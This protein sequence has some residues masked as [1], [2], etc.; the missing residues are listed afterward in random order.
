MGYDLLSTLQQQA[1]DL[2]YYKSEPPMACPNDG[3]PLLSG[4]TRSS[5]ELY[6]PNGDF[7][8]PRDWDPDLHS[9]L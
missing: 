1:A 6:C 2:E 9:G 4:S 8:Y 3:T 7:H 5:G